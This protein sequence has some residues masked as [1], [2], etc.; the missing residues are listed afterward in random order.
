MC[1]ASRAPY[2]ATNPSVSECA[3]TWLQEKA[4]ISGSGETL[5]SHKARVGDLERFSRAL[6]YNAVEAVGWSDFNHNSLVK[7]IAELRKKGYAASTLRRT[8]STWSQFSRWCHRRGYTPE[9]ASGDIKLRV[10]VGGPLSGLETKHF[11][12]LEIERIREALKTA[13]YQKA[14]IWLHR[15]TAI[16]ETLLKLGLRATELCSIK[17]RNVD[18]FQAEGNIGQLHLVDGVK[19]SRRRSMPIP[20]S[21][22]ALLELYLKDRKDRALEDMAWFPHPDS[23]LFLRRDRQTGAPTSIDRHYLYRFINNLM[24]AAGVAKRNQAAV[25]AL[26]HTA[27]LRLARD[28]VHTLL[29]SELMGFGATV[30]STYVAFDLDDRV[31]VLR[32]A[33]W[34]D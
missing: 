22:S 16:F 23:P 5:N 19:G 15:D 7:G 8:W 25:H 29:I 13:K 33:G 27:A 12:D 11:S 31:K 24:R 17:C 20:P 9:D 10:P 26:R 4:A 2:R 1:P 14:D 30:A 18:T 21:I 6:G 3:S 32:A 28:G 34:F